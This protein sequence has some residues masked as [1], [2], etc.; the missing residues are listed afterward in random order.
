MKSIYKI[1]FSV[2]LIISLSPFANVSAA[3]PATS[4]DLDTLVSELIY[5]YG[6]DARTD[7]L[8]THPMIFGISLFDQ[9]ERS[10]Y[11]CSR[12]LPVIIY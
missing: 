4:Q 8:R 1:L 5:Y 10:K 9:V 6:E 11:V 7:I 12:I 3:T 2:L